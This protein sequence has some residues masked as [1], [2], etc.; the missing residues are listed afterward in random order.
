MAFQP[1]LCPRFHKAV[2]GLSFEYKG[3]RIPLTISIGVAKF[4]PSRHLAAGDPDPDEHGLPVDERA[5]REKERD[6]AVLGR[7]IQDADEGVYAAKARGR[8]AVVLSEIAIEA[9]E[10]SK[11]AAV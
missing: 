8:N 11:E 10:K 1:A 6:A 4:E 7:I 9:K 3:T 5:R 2:E